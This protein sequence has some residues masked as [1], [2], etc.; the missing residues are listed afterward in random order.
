[1]KIYNKGNIVYSVEPT[2]YK[3][4]QERLGTGELVLKK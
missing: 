3:I 4:V 1:V 2:N